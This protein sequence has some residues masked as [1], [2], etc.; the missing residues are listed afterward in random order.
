MGTSLPTVS[1]LVSDRAKDRTLSQNPASG[2]IHIIELC[3]LHFNDDMNLIFLKIGILDSK[4]EGLY[5][6][7]L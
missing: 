1:Q 5:N 7:H 4:F 3:L 2:F 6:L